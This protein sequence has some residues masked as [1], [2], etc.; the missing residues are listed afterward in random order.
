MRTVPLIPI[1]ENQKFK[2][3]TDLIQLA[4]LR[5]VYSLC[6]LGC[7][8]EDYPKDLRRFTG[9]IDKTWYRNK[10]EILIILHEIIPE[11]AKV[12]GMKM[13]QT[14]KA[15]TQRSLKAKKQREL[16]L[17]GT[18]TDEV[19]ANPAPLKPQLSSQSENIRRQSI[20][21]EQQFIRKP[22][23]PSGNVKPMLTEKPTV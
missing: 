6:R 21:N 15:H 12:K 19:E 9:L 5:S 13:K 23:K 22:A 8:R 14:E 3:A 2:E 16:Q 20:I 1:F 11:I 10:D 17:S 4:I 18:M 7:L